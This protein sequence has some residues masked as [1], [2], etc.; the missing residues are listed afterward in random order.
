M[1]LKFCKIQN[2]TRTR[3]NESELDYFRTVFR[4]N[5]TRVML[6]IKLFVLAAH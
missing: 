5:V 1:W 6:L 4:G 2:S 3:W